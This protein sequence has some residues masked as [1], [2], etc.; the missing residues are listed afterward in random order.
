[1]YYQIFKSNKLISLQHRTLF[2]MP[3]DD[4]TKQTNKQ[5]VLFIV[6]PKGVHFCSR[7]TNKYFLTW[8]FF[9]I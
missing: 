8:Y 7:K 6:P 4:V 9:F 1:M 2:R 3:F 5:I